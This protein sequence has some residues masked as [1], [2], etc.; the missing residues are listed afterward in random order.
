[1]A[2][3]QSVYEHLA[4]FG[5]EQP[6]AWADL[7]HVNKLRK[8]CQSID[9]EPAQVYLSIADEYTFYPRV[10][11]YDAHPKLRDVRDAAHKGCHLCTLILTWLL[12]MRYRYS[13]G[14]DAL[15]EGLE[16]I[17]DSTKTSRSMLKQWLSLHQFI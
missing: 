8:R 6:P 10:K 14:V 17:C 5:S 7:S 4:C 13:V 2:D 11:L 9:W 15:P 1:M 3:A 12:S 16:K